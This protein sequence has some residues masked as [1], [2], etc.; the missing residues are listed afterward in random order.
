M[1]AKK[2]EMVARKKIKPIRPDPPKFKQGAWVTYNKQQ[3][4]IHH[5]DRRP[6]R[7][8]NNYNLMTLAGMKYIIREDEIT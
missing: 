6:D 4:I 2:H 3:A 8:V 5:V 1:G 7:S